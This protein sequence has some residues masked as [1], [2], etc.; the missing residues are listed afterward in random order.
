[1]AET[2]NTPINRRSEGALNIFLSTFNLLI[3]GLKELSI[4]LPV[5]QLIHNFYKNL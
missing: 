4:I 5:R 2:V 3:V 1:M